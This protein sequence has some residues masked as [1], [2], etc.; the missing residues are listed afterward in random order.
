M[1]PVKVERRS[2]CE[3]HK[4]CPCKW[5]DLQIEGS[6]STATYTTRQDRAS[7]VFYYGYKLL[8]A[9][10]IKKLSMEWAAWSKVDH[11]FL[12][13]IELGITQLHFWIWEKLCSIIIRCL[14]YD[15]RICNLTSKNH[16]FAKHIWTLQLWTWWVEIFVISYFVEHLNL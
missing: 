7:A 13:Q 15:G 9:G 14:R 11:F 5:G 10:S 16:F 3:P 6:G 1:C 12:S 2:L 4:S 8:L